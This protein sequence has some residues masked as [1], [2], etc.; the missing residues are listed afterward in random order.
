M[1]IYEKQIEFYRNSLVYLESLKKHN[2]EWF[3]DY[4][5]FILE[6]VPR[7]SKGLDVGCGMGLAVKLLREA[8]YDMIGLDISDMFLS[9]GSKIYNIDRSK[10][11]CANALHMPFKDKSFDFV[12]SIDFVEHVSVLIDTLKEAGRV[13]KK[14]GILIISVPHPEHD[15]KDLRAWPECYSL[16]LHSFSFKSL[17]ELLLELGFYSIENKTSLNHLIIRAIR[18]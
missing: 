2:N 4:I 16:H 17:K 12:C 14:E 13:L 3:K 15:I 8:G 18:G 9:E 5:D 7:G 10:L 11:I 6:K 1:N